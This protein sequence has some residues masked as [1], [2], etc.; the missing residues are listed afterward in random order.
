MRSW[1]K[2]KVGLAFGV[3]SHLAGAAPA[4]DKWRLQDFGTSD[5]A[6]LLKISFDTSSPG[7][8]LRIRSYLAERSPN[9]PEGIFSRG[10]LADSAGQ[11][12][13]LKY[14]EACAAQA[15]ANLP[16]RYNLAAQYSIAQ[17]YE[18]ALR[19][20][21]D[22]LRIDPKYGSSL[23]L[24][25]AYT[26]LANDL[27]RPQEAQALLARYRSA[28]GGSYIWNYI[29]AQD[30]KQSRDFELAR[31]K[32]TQA[33]RAPDAPFDV[34]QE[35]A[36]L[37]T[38]ELYDSRSGKSR[39]DIA[40]ELV[41]AYVQSGHPDPDAIAY[42]RNSFGSALEGSDNYRTLLEMEQ[43]Y[44]KVLA[45]ELIR[46]AAYDLYDMRAAS[47]WV[48]KNLPPVADNQVPYE[49]M[50][51][52]RAK[53]R[54]EGL[55]PQV[56]AAYRR[57]ISNAYSSGSRENMFREFLVEV[58]NSGVC[59]GAAAVIRELH[60]TM[61]DLSAPE[62]E[63]DVSI[64]NQDSKSAATLL[65]QYK[66]KLSPHYR[67]D[68]TRVVKLDGAEQNREQYAREHPFMANWFKQFG[69]RVEL[70]IEFANGSAALPAG[71]NAEL[72]KL[73]DLLKGPSAAGY[74]FEISGHT[75]NRGA[76]E[77]N[78]KL[79]AARAAAVSA[80]L[81]RLGVPGERLR[82][83]GY[84]MA[85]PLST[86]LSDAGRAR[87]RRVEVR[88]VGTVSAPVLAQ[89]GNLPLGGIMPIPGGR[90]AILGDGPS[91][92]WDLQRNVRLTEFPEGRPLFVTRNG[93]YMVARR[94]HNEVNG[95][96]NIEILAYDIK[97][98]QVIARKAMSVTEGYAMS[99]DNS[100]LAVANREMLTVLSLPE[101][102]VLRSAPYANRAC[103][104]RGVAWLPGDLIAATC[105]N[106]PAIPLLNARTLAPARSLSGVQWVHSLA[107]TGDGRYL[108]AA[109]NGGQVTAWNTAT[110]AVH[111][112]VKVPHGVPRMMVARPDS[113][114]VAINGNG[115]STMRLDVDAMKPIES[116]DGV[117]RVAYSADGSKL[118]RGKGAA[119]AI[120]D[121]GTGKETSLNA[122]GDYDFGAYDM[123]VFPATN[124]VL[125]SGNGRAEIFD[126]SNFSRVLDLKPLGG[127]WLR[128][129]DNVLHSN[130]Y[131]NGTWRRVD[132][133]SLQ[134]VAE[135]RIPDNELLK[136]KSTVWGQRVVAVD[137]HASADGKADVRGTIE[138]LSLD[139][140]ARRKVEIEL[141]TAQLRQGAYATD[142][143]MLMTPDDRWLVAWPSWQDGYG[144]P[145]VKSKQAYVID[146]ASG[147]LAQTISLKA[148]PSDVVISGPDQADF[149]I[150]GGA[151]SVELSTGKRTSQIFGAEKRLGLGEGRTGLYQEFG[152]LHVVAHGQPVQSLNLQDRLMDAGYLP[153]SRLLVLRMRGGS[154]QLR[155]SDTLALKFTL[156]LR[157]KNDWIAYA[158]D[159]TF[160]ASLNGTDA[161]YWNVGEDYLPFDALREKFERP[162]LLRQA[163]GGTAAP[164]TAP[165]QPSAPAQPAAVAQ[166]VQAAEQTA[167]TQLESDAFAPP[168]DLHI[169]GAAERQT[170]A[171]SEAVNVTVERKRSSNEAY[172]LRFTVNGRELK[173]AVGTRGLKRV[174]ACAG[175][176]G[177]C[178]EKHVFNADLEPGN[179]IIQ[180]SLGYKNMWLNPQ[181]IIV[182]R[183]AK[184]AANSAMLPR[185]WFFSV[186]VSDY[187]KS[188]INLKYPHLDAKALADTFERQVG[189]LYSEVH[190][191][192]LANQ[193][194]T[195]QKLTLEMNRFL[196]SAAQQDLIVMFFAGH[197]VL[198]N[199]QTLYFMSHDANPEEPYTGLNVSSIQELLSKRPQT[200]KVL[201]WLD[202][203]HSGAAGERTRA[204]IVSDDAIK[205]LAQGTGVKVMTSSTGREFSLEGPDYMNGH[206]AFTAALIEGLTGEADKKTGDGDGYV[207]VLELETY[208][209]RRVPDTT[210]GKQHP[211][212]AYSS[213][214]Q[215]YPLIRTGQP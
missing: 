138:L 84:G 166:A 92:V 123:E 132:V 8:K 57:A 1:T 90:W 98:G 157:G 2:L 52:A 64:C 185:L 36:D 209:A 62:D 201:L 61:P 120:R 134:V 178:E 85:L 189:K 204:A 127:S 99:P 137:T 168:Y 96:E 160:S 25:H 9:S 87:N 122:E 194:A 149:L 211:T 147:K 68:A 119:Y 192:V 115:S 16:C 196:K 118:Y 212:T 18:D 193:D 109:D 174:A 215:D 108:V 136:K 143:K 129:G 66:N 195:T 37:S 197:G 200:Q 169:D 165:A 202:I 113:A 180:V 208:V 124:R 78:E 182:K 176:T 53:M 153:Q 95:L 7:L 151:V 56:Q 173:G 131:E 47:G 172:Q 104:S 14:Y 181:T 74:V 184:P 13:V 112:Q 100:E 12:D 203:C 21:L 89:K 20:R 128:I 48:D 103:V 106:Y 93:R 67:A 72:A 198:D 6:K 162:E 38:G 177:S 142:V 140:A 121:L 73:A 187:A 207:S 101:L 81:E 77:L 213:K 80:G 24:Y 150:G 23:P 42:I 186:G 27:H 46:A 41:A 4:S 190:T 40:L 3:L 34:T 125:L 152:N 26:T 156:L 5:P 17:R 91:Y 79:S 154:V 139:G 159:G 31:Q 214:F 44:S 58:R 60:R 126:M 35:L 82:A 10:W 76:A 19:V 164:V 161:L 205:M 51:W 155:D 33:S 175:P 22:M 11:G 141:V 70:R 135:G 145:W 97:T 183:A 171:D 167:P 29:E 83:K 191:K 206:G 158:P 146:V 54:T 188:D 59:D 63:I 39:L 71:A 88:P 107:V 45:P 102:K 49:L 55:T 130:N 117:G 179:N 111:G 65:A 163:L 170:S 94:I 110:W 148:E 50:A 144:T 69:D 199:D 114:E 28:L 105:S 133:G 86:N 116:W 30:A 75:D 32:L 43:K 210:R 15:P